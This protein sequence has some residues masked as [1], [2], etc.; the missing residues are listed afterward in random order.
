MT[1]SI[2]TRFRDLLQRVSSR[3]PVASN[4]GAQNDSASESIR[5]RFCTEMP[6]AQMAL[7]SSRAHERAS[8]PAI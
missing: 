8:S 4:P 5:A 7:D 3:G 6:S 2:R 1:E